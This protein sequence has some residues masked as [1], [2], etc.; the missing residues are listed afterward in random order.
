MEPSSSHTTRTFETGKR[1]RREQRRATNPIREVPG[2][3]LNESSSEDEV[4]EELQVP[5]T[6]D[7]LTGNDAVR[8]QCPQNPDDP[9]TSVNMH[10]M[11]R[12]EEQPRDSDAEWFTS[13]FGPFHGDPPPDGTS[14]SNRI[15][16]MSCNIRGKATVYNQANQFISDNRPQHAVRIVTGG[17]AD[18]VIMT[19]A[20]AGATTCATARDFA[21]SKDCVAVT[22]PASQLSAMI[23]ED[24]D[25][26]LPSDPAAG[27]IAVM[28]TRLA[29]AMRGRP[30]KLFAGRLM[31]LTFGDGATANEDSHRLHVIAVYGFAGLQT[32][33]GP[34]ANLALKLAHEL[35]NLLE[36]LEDERVVVVGDFNTVSSP[37]DRLSGQMS[38]ADVN[39]AALWKA[40]ENSLLG[41]QDIMIDSCMHHTQERKPQTR[42]VEAKQNVC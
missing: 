26:D 4:G 32:N 3:Q 16:I 11:K 27:I 7:E 23:L 19:E 15:N 14:R 13:E 17:L 42:R 38:G 2:A 37:A 25:P 34:R 8:T 39:C 31:H 18:I 21:R 36:Q 35:L 24:I 41:F 1:Q 12:N 20:K 29:A 40:L 30:T 10:Y 5:G 28:S 6:H 9:K 22:A 33:T